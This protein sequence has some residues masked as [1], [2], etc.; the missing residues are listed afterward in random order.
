MRSRF[1]DRRRDNRSIQRVLVLVYDSRLF[2]AK[3]QVQ[4][5]G[6]MELDQNL[7]GGTT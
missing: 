5:L 4:N 6:L 7:Q 3:K 2:V 1:F